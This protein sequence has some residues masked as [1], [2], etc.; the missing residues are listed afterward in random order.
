MPMREEILALVRALNEDAPGTPIR[1][2]EAEC[3]ELEGILGRHPEVWPLGLVDA[4]QHLRRRLRWETGDA[5][6]VPA[7]LAGFIAATFRRELDPLA[8]ARTIGRDLGAACGECEC[9]C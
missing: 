9:R 6:A 2:G 4:L 7:C 1:L 3:V 5:E 8:L